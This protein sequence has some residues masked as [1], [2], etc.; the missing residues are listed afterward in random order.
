MQMHALNILLDILNN[1]SKLKYNYCDFIICRLITFT[2]AIV[3]YKKKK[4]I[5]INN[6]YFS[7]IVRDY[8][9][10]YI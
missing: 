9:Y 1:Y 2:A 6:T 4:T 3:L 7:N 10:I 8:T 5:T